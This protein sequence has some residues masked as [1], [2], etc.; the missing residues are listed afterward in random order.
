MASA[1][2]RLSVLVLTFAPVSSGPRPLKQIRALQDRY[3]VTTAGVGPA[4]AGIDDHIELQPGEG[5]N[6]VRKLLFTA[7]LA[8]RLHRLAF[9]ASSRN[10]E[11]WHELHDREWDIILNHDVAT[12]TLALRLRA[13]LGTLTDLHEYAPRQAEDDWKWRAVVGPYFRWLCRHEV[14]KADAIT[15]VAGGI[16]ETYLKEYGLATS[17][18][19]NATPFYE[20][21]PTPVGTP[22]RLVHSGVSV[23]ARQIHVM[24]EAVRDTT[25]NVT[26]DLF[27]VNS[28]PTYY[29]RLVELSAT[30][31]RVKMNDPVPYDQLVG[32]LNQYD[33]GL[34]I[35]APVTFNLE[36]CLPNK[37]F[38]YIQARLGVLVGPSPEMVS[39]INEYGMGAVAAGFDAVSLAAA[40]DA[41]TPEAVGQWKQRSVD[42]AEALSGE[43]QIE[44]WVTLV[45]EIAAR[46]TDRGAAA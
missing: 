28:D 5:S 17:V 12:M 32:T 25:A 33:V 45:D 43:H 14:P 10:Q 46:A 3:D 30:T 8:L 1:E 16:A 2:K 40:L 38:D 29:R 36:W 4:P 18:V 41:L 39:Y 34:A 26:L 31:D 11:A 42:H 9:W 19:V 13:R 27:L 20:L 23:P 24:I 15:S 35:F 6:L 21:A 44:V 22:I 7:V 37:F